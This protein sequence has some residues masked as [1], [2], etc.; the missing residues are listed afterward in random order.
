MT[1]ETIPIR[2]HEEPP[3]PP[4]GVSETMAEWWS[5]IVV[6]FVLDSHHLKLLEAACRAWDRMTE[7]QRIVE[8]EGPVYEDRFGQP[9]KHPA[10][11]TERQARNEFRLLLRELQLDAADTETRLPRMY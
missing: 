3:D 11:D 7:A 1:A 2:P 10:V 6:R 9:K 5:E 4:D 8:E